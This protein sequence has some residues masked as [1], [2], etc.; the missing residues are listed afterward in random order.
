MFGQMDEPI[1]IL[2]GNLF[3][4]TPDPLGA[5]ISPLKEKKRPEGHLASKGHYYTMGHTLEQFL[6][7]F[8]SSFFLPKL[9]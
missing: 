2:F 3:L 8:P 4:V 7:F 1:L 5:H 9:H 6:F